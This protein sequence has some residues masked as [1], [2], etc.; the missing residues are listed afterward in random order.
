MVKSWAQVPMHG[1][2]FSTQQIGDLEGEMGE[3]LFLHTIAVIAAC[4][5]SMLFTPVVRRIAIA[6]KWFDHPRGHKTHDRPVPLLGGAAVYCALLVSLVV[7]YAFSP[8]IFHEHLLELSAVLGGALIVLTLGV[9]DDLHDISPLPKLVVQVFAA[10]PLAVT[11]GGLS[12]ISNPLGGEP[13]NLGPFA[14]PLAVLWIVGLTNALNLIDGLDGLAVGVTTICAVTLLLNLVPDGGVLSIIAITT[15]GAS[16]GFLVFNFPPARIF[17]GD[18]GAFLI[19]FLLAAVSLGGFR[20]GT[21]LVTLLVPLVAL[22]IPLLNTS[23]A[24]LRGIRLRESPL[25]AHRDHLHDR[26]V[27]IGLSPRAAVLIIYAVTAYLGG[28]ALSLRDVPPDLVLRFAFVA[29]GAGI[30]GIRALS[31]VENRLALAKLESA[32]REATMLQDS[33]SMLILCEVDRNAE[34]EVDSLVPNGLEHSTATYHSDIGSL[35][36]IDA[37]RIAIVP[38][39]ELAASPQREQEVHEWISLVQPKKRWV[40]K[41]IREAKNRTSA[42]MQ[43][44]SLNHETTKWNAPSGG[45]L[46]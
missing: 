2:A 10:L 18:G 32:E 14:I 11:Y 25:R 45:A 16:I 15:A 24:L 20:K 36:S 1:C 42:T 26:L 5:G 21:T 30:I 23:L 12:V 17:L 9:V 8:E 35:F 33:D 13:L 46:P 22:G 37:H 7:A 38:N 4:I 3:T 44:R 40:V 34:D 43:P 31:F 41:T 27:R 6:L 39:Q 28:I 29:A 19:G